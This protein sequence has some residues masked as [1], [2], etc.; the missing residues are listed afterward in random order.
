VTQN[1]VRIGLIHKGEHTTM[2]DQGGEGDT[3][4]EGGIP[5]VSFGPKTTTTTTET[6]FVCS[7]STCEIFTLGLKHCCVVV[8]ICRKER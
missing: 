7:V 6:S 1:T 2:R 4:V 5:S 3:V 8:L